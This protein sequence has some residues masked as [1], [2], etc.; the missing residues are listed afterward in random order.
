M[1]GARVVVDDG[2]RFLSRTE[3]KFDL[4]TIDP[5]PPVE[6]G[7]SSLLYSTEFYDVL[8]Q[9]LTP[10]GVLQQ[11]FPGG[12]KEIAKAVVN[13]L[14]DAFP[15]LQI[16]ESFRGPHDVEAPYELQARGLHLIASFQPLA[17]P[18]I[19]QA[20]ARMPE[21]ARE[22]MLWWGREAFGID[23]LETCWSFV[24]DP[25]RFLPLES[26]LPEDRSVRITDDRPYNE[27]F[28]LRRSFGAEA[29]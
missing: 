17:R 8:K 25:E 19:Q 18:T 6:A 14:K 24:L 12:E 22:D 28:W 15:H 1:P 16:I 9:R 21:A 2:R 11:W 5:P 7:G 3:E 10:T 27:Y 20:V 4:I 26:L 23:R 13:T 29:K